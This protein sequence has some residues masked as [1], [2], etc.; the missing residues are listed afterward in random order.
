M[1]FVPGAPPVSIAVLTNLSLPPMAAN[2]ASPNSMK[3][4]VACSETAQVLPMLRTSGPWPEVTAVWIRVCRSD[5]PMTSRLT[6]VPVL[7]VKASSTGVRTCLSLSTLVP[8][9]LAQ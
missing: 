3:P 4:P 6:L 7:A 1:G 2:S 5:Q 8:W 9:L